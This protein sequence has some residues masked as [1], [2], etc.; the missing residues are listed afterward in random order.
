MSHEHMTDGT[1]R[2]NRRT[3]LRAGAAVSAAG[4]A[5]AAGAG[6]PRAAVAQDGGWRRESLTVHFTPVDGVSITLAGSG[7]PQR[8][9]TFYVDGPIYAAGDVNGTQIGTYQCFGHWTNPADA[10][11]VPNQ[12][13]T[14]VQYLMD[15][16][17]IMGLINE[18]G[19]EGDSHVGA[20]QGGTGA[21]AGALGTFQQVSVP[22][23]E[24]PA[25]PVAATPVPG[26]P[27]PG[28]N[29]VEGRFDL[30]LPPAS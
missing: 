1:A 4:A 17:S 30:L 12:R 2:L 19:T 6:V 16:G 26:T 5:L 13:L 11:D 27:M 25:S 23:P 7:P 3:A 9:D 20:V 22:A 29:V 18:L 21:Y 14:T 28:Q 10:T 24:A 8:G 15:D